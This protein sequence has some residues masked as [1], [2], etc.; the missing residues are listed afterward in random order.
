MIWW[1]FIR[2]VQCCPLWLV[3]LLQC[4]GTCQCC[5]LEA[6]PQKTGSTTT[7][8]SLAQKPATGLLPH[9]LARHLQVRSR[10][11]SRRAYSC[12]N[13]AVFFI[14]NFR[15]LSCFRSVWTLSGLSWADRCCVCFWWLSFPCWGC[16]TFWRTI[17]PL[18][19]QP[20][21][22]ATGAFSGKQGS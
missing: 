13:R 11:C 6:T 3:T 8:W 1:S 17:Q 7:Y 12:L 10:Y 2:R 21:L 19:P 20:Y 14:F 16:R 18:L 15:L 4:A 22:V 5:W 9:I